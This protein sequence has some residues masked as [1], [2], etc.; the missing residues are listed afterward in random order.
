MD[1]P[2]RKLPPKKDVMI[3]LLSESNVFVHL[4]PR[5]AGV[6]VPKW[7]TTQPELILQL[8][9]NMP[10]PIPDLEVE[11]DGVS[12]TLSFS[13]SPFWCK[14]PWDAVFAIVSDKDRRGVV[15]PEDV[16]SES[17]LV[18]AAQKAPPPARPRPKL[19]ALG[20]NDRLEPEPDET[21]S[22]DAGARGDDPERPVPSDAKCIDCGTKWLEDQSACPV[23]GASSW[24]G[25][26]ARERTDA[27]G[28]DSAPADDGASADDRA[29]T[30][31]GASPSADEAAAKHGDGTGKDDAAAA[32]RRTGTRP[33]SKGS[34][35][36]LVEA[37]AEDRGA[38]SKGKRGKRSEVAAGGPSLGAGKH[39]GDKSA[40]DK[41]AGDKSAGEKS[42]EGKSAGDKSAEG[43]SAEGTSA[44]GT[45][46][47]GKS[48]EGAVGA[49]ERAL[50]GLGPD[51]SKPDASAPAEA[52]PRRGKKALSVVPPPKSE[53]SVTPARGQMEL[54]RADATDTVAGK[55]ATSKPGSAPSKGAST[56][57]APPKQGAG[58]E[59]RA[60]EKQGAAR[61]TSRDG[62]AASIEDVAGLAG[63]A[64]RDAS[65]RPDAP[66]AGG[67]TSGAT[68]EPP[69]SD[70]SAADESGTKKPSKR[71][72]P[73]YL[74]VVK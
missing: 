27:A 50:G 29:V 49:G 36:K 70:R 9:L 25:S 38:S 31:D 10:I 46:A 15:W 19:T 7:F 13:R 6:I 33:R 68:N 55:D 67:G 23:C 21:S 3:A 62:D 30:I 5:K 37:S 54:L 40:E 71:P 32:K 45:S 47:E 2:P 34:A 73:P 66:N 72:L 65:P 39:A 26:E 12:C 59:G 63:A 58:A 52:S 43:K 18:R 44:E 22:S 4:D 17:Q 41:S 20:P 1:V 42:A 48:A 14:L 35:P 74:R 69:P 24:I 8:G 60:P 28:G 53:P 61:A 51:E 56:K 57:G 64:G 16:P 11:D